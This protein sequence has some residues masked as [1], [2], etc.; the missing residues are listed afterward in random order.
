MSVKVMGRVWD[1]GLPP[2]QRL[3]LLAYADAAEHD[4]SKAFP[5]EDRLAEM[6]G[7]SLTSVDRITRELRTL[8][9]L[10][11]V[12]RGH[13]GR[14]AEFRVNLEHPALKAPHSEGQTVEEP[15]TGDDL[16]P[17]ESPSH[18]TESPS[19]AR[20]KPHTSEDPPVLDPS[21]T[22]VLK[23]EEGVASLRPR[24]ELWDIV[25]DVHG[26]PANGSERGKF[27]RAVKLLREAEVSPVEYPGLVAAFVSR[28]GGSQPAVM[29]VASRVGEM[30]K[31]VQAGPIRGP[32]ADVVLRRRRMEALT[33]RRLE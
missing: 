2:H 27:N 8:G 31:F 9:V 15:I 28:Y 19:P 14:R 23:E 17:T 26:A 18:D 11:Q 6:T 29:T 7:Y 5:G 33:D 21:S 20:R 25:V 30:R 13:R 32:D 16:S 24:D 4:G 10:V 1:S 22:P 12:G 3:V